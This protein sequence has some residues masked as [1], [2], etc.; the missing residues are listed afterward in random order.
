MP[1]AALGNDIHVNVS[2][3]N[4]PIKQPPKVPFEYPVEEEGRL[5]F[6]CSG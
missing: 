5:E 2:S 3:K 4:P 1:P 6:N